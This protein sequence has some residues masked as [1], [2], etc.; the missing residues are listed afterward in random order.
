MA[1]CSY[2]DQEMT[3]K[4]G[5]TQTHYDDFPDKIRR[6]RIPFPQE[7]TTTCHD[8]SAPPGTLHHP[9]C[10]TERCPG[11]GGQAIGCG[12]SDPEEDEEE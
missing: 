9:G 8:C 1:V 4:V 7:H 5:C 10:D 2:C 3:T 12:C 6:E 11:C